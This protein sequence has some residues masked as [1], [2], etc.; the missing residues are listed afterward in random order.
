MSIPA[1]AI[2]N[3]TPSVLGA[4]GNPLSLNGLILSLNQILP[5]GT[6]VSFVNST[7]VG[8]YFGYTSQE[9]AMA[10]AYFGG[11]TNSTQKPGSLLFAAYTKVA[12]S[13]WVRGISN[14]LTLAQIQ[15]II[16]AVTAATTTIAP[17]TGTQSGYGVATVA[18]VSSGTL[19]PGML[20][21]GG[22]VAAGTRLGTQLTGTTGGAGTY[23]VSISQTC[24]AFALTGNYDMTIT[25]DGTLKTVS[26]IN[27]SAA[28]SFSNAASLIATA[29]GGSCV[30]SYSSN[31]SAYTF[32]SPTTGATST[33]T[34][35]AGLLATTFGLTAALG[36][37]TSVGTAASVPATVMS[38]IV[39]ATS[40]WVAFGQAFEPDASAGVYTVKQAFATWAS[41][42]NGQFL[43]VAS[44]ANTLNLA[45]NGTSINTLAQAC[46]AN[47][48]NGC[49]VVYCD[50][51][52]DP[53]D[54]GTAFVLGAIAS[55]DFNANNGRIVLHG[56]AGSAIPYSVQDLTSFTNLIANGASAYCAFA[57]ANQAFNFFANGY[58]SGPQAFIDNYVDAI[59]LDAQFQLALM[60]LIANTTSIPV[61][62]VGAS[63][64]R[65][66]CQ[67]VIDQAVAFGMIRK[68]VAI[69][70]V[71]AATASAAAGVNITN[72]LYSQGYYLGVPIP[73]AQIRT[74]R[75]PWPLI[76]WYTNGEGLQT[77]IL[78]TVNIR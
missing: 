63:L 40:N 20:L 66:A 28:S 58:C 36:A 4:G 18:T 5:Y 13:A 2:V 41:G 61:T 8:N 44:D 7:A 77:I 33:M 10:Q 45:A 69:T 51:T 11:Y 29:I 1:S 64:I 24:A 75:G 50:A 46:T 17:G 68:N 32:T 35:S 39:T 62:P 53:F 43:Y 74:A 23:L 49:S 9:Y 76:F 59:W 56:K 67:P 73:S 31:F 38:N 21:T 78:A 42:T 47:S 27:L 16:P 54:L 65:A 6:P 26:T 48:I 52:L 15:A 14:S 12:L 22:T 34:G 60:S 25:V 37:V 3:V 70:P 55:I 72:A 71:Q 19:V 30:G 57:T